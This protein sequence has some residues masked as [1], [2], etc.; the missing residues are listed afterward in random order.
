MSLDILTSMK[1]LENYT[2]TECL[3]MA[4]IAQ[5]ENIDIPF[6]HINQLIENK[7]VVDRPKDKLDVLALEQIQKLR[8][9]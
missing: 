2:F 3:Q 1:G 5:I 8:E 7:K 4:S 6:L 9:P